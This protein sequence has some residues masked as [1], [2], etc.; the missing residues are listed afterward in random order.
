MKLL[1]NVLL[2]VGG[3]LAG[4]VF[5]EGFL[6]AGEDPNLQRGVDGAGTYEGKIV[7]GAGAGAGCD[8]ALDKSDRHTNPKWDSFREETE[9][10]KLKSG[11]Q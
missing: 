7:T 10:V 2:A 4:G 5:A 6:G 1:V 11:A 9:E 8:C 3:L